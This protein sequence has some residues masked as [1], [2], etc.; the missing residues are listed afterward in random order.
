MSKKYE[1][2]NTT[3]ELNGHTLHRI[4]LLRDCGLHKKGTYGGWIESEENLSHSGDCFVDYDACVYGNAKIFGFAQV[5]EYARVCGEA[6]VYGHAKIHGYARVSEDAFVNHEAEIYGYAEVYGFAQVLE[7]AKVFG[8]AKVYEAANI[9]GNACIYGNADVSGHAKV[10]DD[11]HVRG[12]TSLFGETSIGGKV[13]INDDTEYITFKNWWSSGR[14]F[15]WTKPNNMWKV[16]CFYGTGEELIN[17]AYRDSELSGREYERV[18]L[19]VESIGRY[20][21]SIPN[22]P[23]AKSSFLSRLKSFITRSTRE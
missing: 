7:K 12:D 21:S 23:S 19:Y 9:H 3:S 2:T 10:C 16:G 11:A 18:V 4:K 15:T 20:N 13:A 6:T 22:A 14:F 17:K 5:Y 8:W 1:L